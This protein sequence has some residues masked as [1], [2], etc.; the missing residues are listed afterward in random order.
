MTGN[1]TDTTDDRR[2]RWDVVEV[3]IRMSLI[4]GVVVTV[5]AVGWG[6][7]TAAAQS[8][9]NSTNVSDAA[10]Y[11]ESADPDQV[12]ADQNEWLAGI[13]EPT[14]TGMADLL[15]RIGTVWVG[16]GSG[17]GGGPAGVMLTGLVVLGT[18]LS[19][20]AATRVGP[21]AGGALAVTTVLTL[22]GLGLIPGWVTAVALFI[23]GAVA[24]GVMR[25]SI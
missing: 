11:Y 9:N 12:E 13:E 2:L 17:Q 5:G 22:G 18:V 19:T 23:L 25:R 1:T 24:V 10:P 3:L 14:L 21:V 7:H 8:T 4:L 15:T 6:A 20:A 16:V